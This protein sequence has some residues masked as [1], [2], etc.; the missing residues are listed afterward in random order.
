M[1]SDPRLA[2]LAV[3][4]IGQSK[5][6]PFER[7][8]C[9]VFTQALRDCGFLSSGRITRKVKEEA[10]DFLTSGSSAFQ[11]WCRVLDLHPDIVRSELKRRL[12]LSILKQ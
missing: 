12:T 9:A 7:L 11:F 1:L 5:P 3:T 8:A 4:P 6:D 2:V 10:I